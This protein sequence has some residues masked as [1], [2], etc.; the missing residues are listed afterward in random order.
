MVQREQEVGVRR[1]GDHPL[2]P[3]H[4]PAEEAVRVLTYSGLVNPAGAVGAAPP[5][6]EGESEGEGAN[7]G[8]GAG[9]GEGER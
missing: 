1:D 9:E 8:A 6:D 4:Q 2:G 3:R 5:P 7:K